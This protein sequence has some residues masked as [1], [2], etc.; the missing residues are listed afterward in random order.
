MRENEYLELDGVAL[1]ERLRAGEAS[2]GELM[3]CAIQLARRINPAI[4]AICHPAYESSQQLADEWRGRGPFQGIP[5]LLKD[6]GLAATKFESS[7]GSALFADSRYSEDATLVARF[8]AAGLIAFARTTVP[9][10]CMAPTTE[11]RHNG[12]ATRNPYDSTRSAGGSSGGAAAS[13]A[14]G[15]VPVAHGSDGGGSIR[16]PASCCGVFGLK[17]SRGRVPMGPSRGEGWGGLATDGV[18]SRTVRDTATALDAV[19]HS[20][21]G[22]P[23]AAPPVKGRLIDHVGKPFERPLRICVW[24]EP[25]DGIA[26]AQECATAVDVTVQ[27]LRDAGHFV[28]YGS[29]SSELD[30]EGFIADHTRVLAASLVQSVDDRLKVLGRAL[31]ADDLEPAM[32]DAYELG[33]T[34]TAQQYATAIRR[35][36]MIGRVLD[37]P[38]ERFDIVL[39][40][41]LAQ[42]PATLGALV[43]EGSF[44]G[45]RRRVSR[46]STYLA[47]VNAS[48]QPAASVPTYW[49]EDGIPVG[50]QLIARYGRED[51]IVQLASQLESTGNWQPLRRRPSVGQ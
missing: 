4:N 42:L 50:T 18:I 31:R 21:P 33:K 34:I 28:E 10:M 19:S 30:Y 40:P 26:L 13:V 7:I 44:A 29:A 20:E 41:T 16:I 37:A 15:I 36:H 2:S 5:F 27:L 17:P 11:A 48:G 14:A 39:T 49:T 25:P 45:F 6:S 8:Q 9:E 3:A 43:M 38:F 35:F 23:Y 47:I 32:H 46:Y 24:K 51:L 12:N 22:A 1:A